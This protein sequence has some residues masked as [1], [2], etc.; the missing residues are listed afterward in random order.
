MLTKPG[1]WGISP[2]ITLLYAHLNLA[3]QKY[4]QHMICLIGP[5]EGVPAILSCLWLEGSLERFYPQY[6]RDR[7]GLYNLITGFGVAGGF[8]RFETLPPGC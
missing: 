3:I 8:P 5:N 4:D 1:C 2:G 6:S 7:K